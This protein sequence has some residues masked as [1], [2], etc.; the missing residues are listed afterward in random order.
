MPLHDPA[1][2]PCALQ[3]QCHQD[4]GLH[5]PSEQFCL[6]LRSRKPY[7][8]PAQTSILSKPSLQFC[9][10]FAAKVVEGFWQSPCKSVGILRENSYQ[11]VI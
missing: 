7:T 4:H 5:L 9:S 3:N 10:A 2:S 6:L 11:K 1:D 8:V